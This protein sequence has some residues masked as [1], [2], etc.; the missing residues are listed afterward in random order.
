MMGLAEDGGLLLPRTI[1]RIGNETLS[2]WQELT[3]PELAFE[4]MSRFIDDIPIIDLQT[5][6]DKSYK[7]FTH[8][9]I[10]PLVEH[11]NLHILELFHGPTLAFKDVALQFLGN[12]F[13]Y[14][15]KK[16]DSVLNILER[17]P[18]I[19]AVLPSTVS[20]VKTGST[21]SSFTLT[22]G[23]VQSRKSR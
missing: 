8:P 14:L 22:T 16:N 3:Y 12:L 18:V 4:I 21:F 19:P 10:L 9:E 1:P 11:G 15:L 23:S 5:L 13:E 2:G 20:G 7:S 17:L 6:I